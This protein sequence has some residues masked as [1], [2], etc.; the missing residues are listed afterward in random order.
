MKVI[1]FGTLDK[2][3]RFYLD[4]G[5]ELMTNNGQLRIFSIHLSGFLYTLLR[6]KYSKCISLESWFLALKK[7]RHYSRL[8]ETTRTY[9]GVTIEEVISYHTLLSSSN[10]VKQLSLQAFAYIDIVDQSFAQ[11][12]PDYI[13]CIGDTKMC[14]QIAVA[15]AKARDIEIRYIEQ[16]PFSR[17][18]YDKKGVNANLS[19]RN[20]SMMNTSTFN[21]QKKIISVKY[22]RSPLYRFIDMAFM[23]SLEKTRIYPPDLKYTDVNSFRLSKQM[24]PINLKAG[25]RFL[26]VCQIPADV[27]SII[28]SP[29]FQSH[30]DILKQ[31]HQHLP[32]NSYLVVREHP[33][34]LGKYHKEFYN[35]IK[36]HSIEI[37]NHSDLNNAISESTVVLVNNSTVGFESICLYKT[38]VVLGN[39]FYDNNQI[40][41]KL[42]NQ[43]ELK[44][45]LLNSLSYIPNKKSI[46]KF[47]DLLFNSVLIEGGI[48]D[49]YLIASKIIVRDLILKK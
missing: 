43:T 16:G 12:N 25:N 42:K 35:Y 40:C 5:K 29:H 2:F 46:D 6:F 32:S 27:N 36:Q 44:K 10:S 45:L 13:I 7:R 49:K 8:Y 4:I 20:Q 14:I 1:C 39:A 3:S 41:L 23:Y 37:E 21:S 17:T 38:T 18:F 33:L 47:K 19:M 30:V 26:L 34:F 24:T 31:V 9:K 11:F 22:R 48:S 15:L 28:H